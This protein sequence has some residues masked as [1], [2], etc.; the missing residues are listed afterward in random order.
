MLLYSHSPFFKGSAIWEI[1]K[2][3]NPPYLMGF[4]PTQSLLRTLFFI[5]MSNVIPFF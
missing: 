1:K 3:I 4:A 2:T 5:L